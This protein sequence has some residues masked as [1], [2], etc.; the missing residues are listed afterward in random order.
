M[1]RSLVSIFP[2]ARK[3]IQGLC[4]VAVLLVLPVHLSAQGPPSAQDPISARER[5]ALY[6]ARDSI[7]EGRALAESSCGYCHGLNGISS[8]EHRPHLAGQRTVY[9]YREMLA[10]KEGARSNTMM[11]EAVAF[12]D[13]DAL[14]KTAIYYA[15][16]TPP[17]I[18]KSAEAREAILHDLGTDPLTAVAAA[19]AGCGSCHGA[20]GNSGI[21]GMPSL[22][23]QHS[24]YFIKAMQDYQ[25]GNRTDNMMQMLVATLDEETIANMGKFYALQEPKSR[26][27]PV[28]GDPDAGR[29]AAAAC[30]NCHAADG[31][32]SGADM[33]SLAGQDAVYLAK[34][35]KTYLNGQ[36]G[37]EPMQSAMTG[38]DEQQINDLAAFYSVQKPLMRHLRKPLTAAQWLDR[39]DRCHGMNGNSTDPRYARLSGQNEQYLL[40]VL[41]D[42]ANGERSDSIMHAMSEPLNDGI[43]KRLAAYYAIQEPRSVVYFELPCTEQEE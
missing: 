37:H 5:A 3:C 10:Y 2:D 1:N 16:L 13:A 18:S 15:S 38:F 21:P 22:T 42:Y 40:D 6:P 27:A 19:T 28:A 26:T 29:L 25:V 7:E 30:A 4:I 39:C 32:A 36:R 34:A 24:D 9:L 8:D 43:I 33:P 20:K 17:F 41:A 31:N 14:L 11:R 35:M 23:T 12:L